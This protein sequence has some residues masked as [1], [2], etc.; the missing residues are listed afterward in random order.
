MISA[1][2]CIVSAGSAQADD[3]QAARDAF[4]KG[5]AAFGADDFETAVVA[6]RRADDLA[7]SWKLKYNIGQCEAALK[8]Y[9]LAIEAFELYLAEGGDEVPEERRD[10][11]IREL[12]RLREMVGSIE[13][14]ALGGSVV[15]VDDVERGRTPLS[16][17]IKVTAGIDHTVRVEHEGE[18]ILS[19]SVKVSGGDTVVVEADDAAGG[20]DVGERPAPQ[21]TTPVAEVE[22]EH[23]ALWPAGWVTLGAGGALLIAGGATFGAM[24]SLDNDLEKVCT[25][26]PDG[27]ECPENRNADVDKRDNMAVASYVLLGVGGAA[28]ITGA[29]LLIVDATKTTSTGEPSDTAI[30]PALGPDFTGL[31]ITR[32][33]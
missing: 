14:R 6:F 15:Y 20:S 3:Q 5:V 16:G 10:E 2:A 22:S 33:F 25:E 19:R 13:V 32:R 31:T 26:G 17:A 12:K 7:P 24:F 9:G 30:A 28:A 1:F 23:T 18:E 11:V 8:H 27:N 4:Q 21:P 29:V